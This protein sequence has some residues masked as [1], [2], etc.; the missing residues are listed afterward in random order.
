MKLIGYAVR[1]NLFSLCGPRRPL[2]VHSP[3]P[4]GEVVDE[5]RCPGYSSEDF[6]PATPGDVLADR[7]RVLVKIGWGTGSTVWLAEDARRSV[8]P[9]R[10]P[11]LRGS[12]NSQPSRYRWQSQR[13]AVLKINNRSSHVANHER[14]IED[15]IARTNPS[16][17]G[18]GILRT[19]FESFEVNG[20]EGKHL[21]L[22]YE[23][24]REPIWMFQRRFAHQKLPL[25]I[26]KAYLQIL[27]AG[28]DYLHSECNI[29]HTGWQ[30]RRLLLTFRR[31]YF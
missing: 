4:P 20:P 28:L 30:L 14:D 7:Y 5:E 23:P 10:P 8:M 27:L 3:L 29:V 25:S 26:V 1:R 18:H 17:R 16:H 6:Y 2:R 19:C 31:P 15:H 22:A 24:M 13:I 21:C 11:I 9:F 12:R